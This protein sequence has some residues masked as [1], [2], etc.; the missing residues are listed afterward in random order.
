MTT[1]ERTAVASHVATT[2]LCGVVVVCV[3]ALTV[4][5]ERVTD[6]ITATLANVNRPC[7]G[8]AGPD[9]CGALAQVNKTAIAAGDVANAAAKQVE[10]SGTLIT[11][12]TRNLDAV[13]SSVSK[14]TGNL[15]KTSDALSGSANAITET[16]QAVTQTIGTANI[17]LAS[18]TASTNGLLT[19]ASTSVAAIQPLMG[20][21]TLFVSHAD[22]LV[23]NPSALTIE[24]NFATMTTTAN[25]MMLTGDQVETKLAKCTLHATFACVFKSD[26]LF[27]AQVTGYLLR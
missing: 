1:P 22:D 26:I 14:L 9:A 8:I 21:A 17:S 24:N 23:S 4:A 18:V 2:I 10:Q 27:G 6:G 3:I 25:H 19:T 20:R 13:G 7:K 16:A 11:A 5:A 15:S 12:T